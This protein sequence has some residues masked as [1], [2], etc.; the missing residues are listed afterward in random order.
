MII[1]TSE[2]IA[3]HRIVKTIGTVYGVTVR[4]RGVGGNF[5]ASF[6]TIFGGEVKEYAALVEETRQH[7][8]D[9][10]S[11]NASQMGA[12]AVIM[13]RFDSCEMMQSMNEVVAFGTAVVIEAE[14]AD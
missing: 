14:S 7:A 2:H 8:L 12:N 4:S 6:R 5:K 11:V 1:V 3:G 9:R 10:L 13:T